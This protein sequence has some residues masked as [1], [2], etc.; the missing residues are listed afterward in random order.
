[1]EPLTHVLPVDDLPDLL[2][3]VRSDILVLQVVRMLP[4]IN[5]QERDQSS[6]GYKRM[7]MNEKKPK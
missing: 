3:V 1:M 6:C 7:G 2:E 4:D 5:A